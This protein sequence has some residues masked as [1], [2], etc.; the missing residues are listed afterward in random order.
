[1]NK[2]NEIKLTEET[3]A[4]TTDVDKRA[5]YIPDKVNAQAYQHRADDM[6]RA[7]EIGMHANW[8][9]DHDNNKPREDIEKAQA[10]VEIRR[11]IVENENKK[12]DPSLI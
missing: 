5:N 12:E 8:S 9:D 1:M 10:D 2:D 3:E 6:N 11:E 4:K 7:Q